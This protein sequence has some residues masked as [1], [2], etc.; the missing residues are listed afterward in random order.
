MS[1]MK[2]VRVRRWL[3]A[4]VLVAMVALPAGSWIIATTTNANRDLI[5][6]IQAERL[7]NIRQNC[8]DTNTRHDVTIRR[9]HQ[10][11]EQLP[12]GPRKVRAV[13]GMAGSVALIDALAPR[14]DCRA[15]AARQVNTQ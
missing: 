4:T 15:L 5:R 10:L 1:P 2:Q 3:V 13:Q 7:R 8:Q 9:L 14:R 6:A 12:P 11:V